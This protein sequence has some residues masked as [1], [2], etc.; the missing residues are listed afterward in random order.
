MMWRMTIGETGETTFIGPSGNFCFLVPGSS[1]VGSTARSQG[2]KLSSLDGKLWGDLSK[3]GPGSSEQIPTDPGGD[4]PSRK[5]I[6]QTLISLFMTHINPVHQ[7]V[8]ARDFSSPD[9]LNDS[10][11][12]DLPPELEF[13]KC[14]ILAA[15][16]LYSAEPLQQALGTEMAARAEALALRT[17]RLNPCVEVVQA[18]SMLCWRE[19]A[20]D[21]E[22]MAWMYNAMATSLAV[23]LGLS[24]NLLGALGSGE[25]NGGGTVATASQ[26]V[27]LR[28]FWS[29]LFLDR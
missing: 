1:L 10:S 5:G 8:N 3:P 18:L 26:Q 12:E 15:G 4:A 20:L 19:L 7:I 23:H 9:T 22:N 27:R 16:A 13:L 29:C 17:S 24:A 14:A 2:T 28:T 21:N 25:T 6:A 11:A